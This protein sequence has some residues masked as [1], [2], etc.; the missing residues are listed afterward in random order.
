METLLF[1]LIGSGFFLLSLAIAT[2][3]LFIADLFAQH[4][5]H[6]DRKSVV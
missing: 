3:A 2:G 4:L 6:K 1:R 5:V